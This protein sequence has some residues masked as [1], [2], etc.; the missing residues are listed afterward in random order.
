[1]SQSLCFPFPL[2]KDDL[3]ALSGEILRTESKAG[4]ANK[5]EM[6]KP[7]K[8]PC[9]TAL[10]EMLTVISIGR[11]SFKT[12]GNKNCMAEPSIAPNIAAIN[13]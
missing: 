9:A 7:S 10:Q 12:R 13:P 1:M 6:I 5:I 8:M 11:K 3:I 4:S 2:S